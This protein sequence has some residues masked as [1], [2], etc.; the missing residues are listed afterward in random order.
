MKEYIGK[1]IKRFRT[2]KLISARELCHDIS[3]I[4]QLSNIENGIQMPS[5]EKLILYLERLNVSYDEF[6]FLMNDDYLKSKMLMRRNLTEYVKRHNKVGLQNLAEEAGE[7]FYQYEDIYFQH[8]QSIA[9]AMYCLHE[10]NFDYDQARKHL[11]PIEA[12][13][14]NIDELGYYE[15][16]LISQCL[17]MFKLETALLFGKR[18]LDAIEERYFFYKNEVEGCILLENL[19]IYC[20]D[21]EKYY[22]LS[23]KYSQLSLNLAATTDDATRALHAKIINQ[24]AYFKLQNGLFN[25]EYLLSLV[26][27]FQ[28][29]EWK[30]RHEYFLNFIKKHGIIL[31]YKPHSVNETG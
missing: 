13:L 4:Q 17:F 30:G 19:A 2:N 22:H 21:H 14:I 31:N 9:N 15:V 23:L 8:A 11:Q 20:L 5:A 3:T 16:T 12:Y 24:V 26:D 18:A 10:T 7:L 25:Y 6:I 27:T 28:L 1:A 29:L